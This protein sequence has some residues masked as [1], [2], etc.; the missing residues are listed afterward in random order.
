MRRWPIFV[1]ADRE[2]VD[3]MGSMYS[4]DKCSQILDRHDTSIITIIGGSGHVINNL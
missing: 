3:C 4:S 1:L 2:L